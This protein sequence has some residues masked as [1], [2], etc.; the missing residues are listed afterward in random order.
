MPAISQAVAKI[1]PALRRH[2]RRR[3]ARKR[4]SIYGIFAKRLRRAFPRSRHRPQPRLPPVRYAGSRQA[5]LGQ[6]T[7]FSPR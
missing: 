4:L 1:M 5:P 7:G 6:D 2:D 3:T